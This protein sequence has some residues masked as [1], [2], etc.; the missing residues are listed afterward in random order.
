[1]ENLQNRAVIK[2]LWQKGLSTKEIHKDMIKT[3]GESAVS[4]SLV[5]KWVAE[6]K[7]GRDSINDD[8]IPGRPISVRNAETIAK[9]H[10]LIM[11]DRRLSIRF[12]A[13]EVGV[14]HTTV[15]AILKEDL[16]MR[17]LSARWVPKLLTVD[18]KRIRL[19]MSRDNLARFNADPEDFLYR[20]VTMDE[21][22][23][24]HFTPETKM[25]SK[26]WKHMGS[27]PPKKARV[28]QSANKVMASIFWDAD[29]I[30]LIDFL[31]RGHT[32]TGEY[33]SNLLRQLRAAI[34]EK[35]RG[36]LT[37]GV[38]FHQDNAPVHK[39]TIAMATIRE[40]GFELLQHPPYSP[41]LAPSDYY[42]FSYLKKHLAGKRFYTDNEVIEATEGF[43]RSQDKPFFRREIQML[44]ERWEWCVTL[45]GSYVE[46]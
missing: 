42:L 43:L 15:L 6:F 14:S 38:L 20:F 40:Q 44:Q 19:N 35:R 22:W 16:A 39:S 18:Q 17:K 46:K 27:P 2:Y 24:H 12:I 8:D 34:I 11:A 21:T 28:V 10:D 26:Q 23:C 3:L 31:E 41:D 13:S 25:M 7:R 32:V 5:K 33:Y 29:G 36:K 37:R 9:V 4:Y 45:A 30:L 1:M